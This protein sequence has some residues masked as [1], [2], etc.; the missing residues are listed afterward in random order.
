MNLLKWLES[1]FESYCDGV[2]EHDEGIKIETLDNPG[3][4][5]DINLKD[6]DLESKKFYLVKE[7]RTDNDWIH[8][9]VADGFFKGRGGTSNLEEIIKIFHDWVTE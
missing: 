8:C 5:L 3:W 7:D 6:T 4:R 2:W 1:W 9:S